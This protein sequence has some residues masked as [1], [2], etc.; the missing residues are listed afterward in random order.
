[1]VFRVGLLIG[2]ALLVS[3]QST[4][5]SF[6]CIP[7]LSTGFHFD[8]DTREWTSVQFKADE[9]YIVS[10]SARRGYFWEVRE[11]GSNMPLASCKNDFNE[12]GSMACEGFVLFR[13]HR[14]NLRFLAVTQLGYWSDDLSDNADSLSREGANEPAMTIGRCARL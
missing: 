6:V 3:A 12:Y 4:N 8:R 10:R 7:D 9:R 13:M 14:R 5:E 2:S 1:M 11:T